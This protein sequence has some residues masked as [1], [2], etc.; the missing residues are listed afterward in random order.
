MSVSRAGPM[1]E[2]EATPVG[3]RYVPGGIFTMGSDRF[4]PEEAPARKVRVASFYV[5]E[6][7]VTNASSTT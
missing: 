3:M 1:Q 4:Y 7:P 6:T 2:A 5:D